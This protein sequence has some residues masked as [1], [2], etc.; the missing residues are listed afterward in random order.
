[1]WKEHLG[2][3]AGV[4]LTQVSLNVFLVFRTD[5]FSSQSGKISIVYGRLIRLR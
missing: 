1:M 4:H 2:T 5:Q 3:Q